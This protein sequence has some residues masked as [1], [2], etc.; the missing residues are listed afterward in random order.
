MTR[1]PMQRLMAVAAVGCAVGLLAPRPA[2]A[3]RSGTQAKK[4]ARTYRGRLGPGNPKIRRENGK[5]YIWAGGGPPG[6]DKAQW[7]DFTGAPFPPE[8]LQFGIGADRIRSI[9]DPLFVK[10]DDPRLLRYIR[11]SPYRRDE[12][13]KTNDDILVIGV[14][15]GGDVKAYPI[16]LLDYHELV[17]DTIAGKPKTVG[18]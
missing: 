6:S 7:F 1:G 11:P 13:P 10:P 2:H 17:N 4:Q 12:R 14:A 8:E 15:Q 9:D 16:A 5:V 3:Q 18:W